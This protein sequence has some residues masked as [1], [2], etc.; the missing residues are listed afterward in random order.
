MNTPRSIA[1]LLCAA[2]VATACEKNAVQDITSPDAGSARVK[3]FNFG[4]SAPAVNFYANDTKM[5]AINLGTCAIL[6]DAN[7]ELCTTTGTEST[8]GVA[9]GGAGSSG[10]YA[11][12]QPGQYTLSGK[13]AAATDKDLAISSVPATIADGKHYSFFQSGFYNTTTKTVDGFIVEDAFPAAFDYAVAY[14]RFVNAIS[15]ANPMTLYA[16]HTTTSTEE[17]VGGIVAYKAGGAF[18]ALPSGV[19]D[20]S[21]R[22]AGAS[23]NAIARAGVSFVAGRVYTI[24]A[25]G[26]ITITSTTAVNRPF[27]DNTANR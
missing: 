13:I 4:V 26:D 1:M 27:L 19:Y 17:V 25:R 7:R 15:N 20:L 24:T 22:Y 9:Y 3:F 21:T 11:A 18:T 12:I 23:T 6:T 16:R 2:V 10:F 5:T 14:V 8:G